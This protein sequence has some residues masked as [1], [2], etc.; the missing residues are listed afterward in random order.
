MPRLL[1]F[2]GLAALLALLLL[3]LGT[4]SLPWAGEPQPDPD[5]PLDFERE[6]AAPVERAKAPPTLSTA[7]TPRGGEAKARAGAAGKHQAGDQGPTGPYESTVIDGETQAPLEEVEL[8]AP[9]GEVLGA[10]DEHG[11]WFVEDA[12][13]TRLGFRAVLQGY[14]IHTGSASPDRPLEVALH[15]GVHLKGIV[16]RAPSDKPLPNATVRVWD[17]DWGREIVA[18]STDEAGAF[19]MHAVRPHHPVTIVVEAPGLAPYLRRALFGKAPPEQ[20]ILRV[21]E[22]GRVDGHVYGADGKPVPNMTV[23]LMPTDRRPL[24]EQLAKSRATGRQQLGARDILIART[25]TT[26]TDDEGAFQFEGVEATRPLVPAAFMTGRHIVRGKPVLLSADGEALTRDIHLEKSA[27]LWVSIKDEAGKTLSHAALRISSPEGPVPVETTD[28]WNEGKLLIEGLTPGKLGVSASLPGRP[29]PFDRIEVGPGET[30][31]LQL[32]FKAGRDVQGVVLDSNG[33]PLWQA[34]VRWRGAPAESLEVRT[35]RAGRFHFRGVQAPT[36]IVRVNA[37]DLPHTRQT[38]ESWKSESLVPGEGPLRVTLEDGTAVVGRFPELPVG[39]RLRCRMISGRETSDWPLTL[40][41]RHGFRRDGPDANT[42][43]ARF[44]FHVRGRAPLIVDE[45]TP[46]GSREERDLGSLLF[47]TTNPRKGRVVGPDRKPLHGA[48]VTIA[49]PWSD[50]STRTDAD[51]DFVLARLPDRRI[52]VKIEAPGH[53][54]TRAWLETT[55][56]FRRQVFRLRR[57]QRVLVRVADREGRPAAGFQ[58]VARQQPE[59]RKE[60]DP[61]PEDFLAE[62]NGKGFVELW[63]PAGPYAFFAFSPSHAHLQATAKATVVAK[64]RGAGVRLTL[65]GSLR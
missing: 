39:T 37:R 55:S 38:Y 30:G 48:R 3:L 59:N 33:R 54:A 17:L 21:A 5:A 53:T 10:T 63:L 26:T 7:T 41:D 6:E 40:D 18:T 20:Y 16:V 35:D 65:N 36:G 22:G 32:T 46:F 15:G 62:A 19:R 14:V 34:Q 8:R 45:R 11:R 43:G 47:E 23:W 4:D 56:Q 52:I 42:S 24:A 58:V 49:E 51:G 12:G 28:R 57:G 9:D 29:A 50:R 64:K 44:V 25:A 60:G 27:S 13:V 1:I 2:L 61:L 31:R